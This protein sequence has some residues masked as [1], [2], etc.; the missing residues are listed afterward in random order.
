MPFALVYNSKS[1][2]WRSSVSATNTSN[3]TQPSMQGIVQHCP[4]LTLPCT[5]N[6]LFI[7]LKRL[8]PV[9]WRGRKHLRKL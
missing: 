3:G 7:H 5:M 8:M 4:S 6:R 2:T 9:L 1:A